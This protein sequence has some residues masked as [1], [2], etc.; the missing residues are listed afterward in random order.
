MNEK[1]EY[2]P[3]NAGMCR[4]AGIDGQIFLPVNDRKRKET[5]KMAGVRSEYD[6]FSDRK[7]RVTKKEPKKWLRYKEALMIYPVSRGTLTRWAENCNAVMDMNG[8]KLLDA[9]RL[10]KYV[11]S[12]RVDGGVW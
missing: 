2:L 5:Y 11:E 9:E 10:E 1:S 8:S 3:I 4:Y 7:D 12:K 6:Y